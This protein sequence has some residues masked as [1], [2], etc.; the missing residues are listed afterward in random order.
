[1]SQVRGPGAGGILAST[2]PLRSPTPPA[3]LD[4]K[5]TGSSEPAPRPRVPWHVAM[6]TAELQTVD[7]H[8]DDVGIDGD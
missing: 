3:A 1:M 5:L 4:T 8:L 6:E 7:R 2:V